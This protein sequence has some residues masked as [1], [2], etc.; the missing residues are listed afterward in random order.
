M[1]TR[2]LI[3]TTVALFS[4]SLAA[5][6]ADETMKKKSPFVVADLDANGKIS[7]SEYVAAMNGKLDETAA[8]ARFA[9]LDKD[10]DGS[11]TRQEFST[12]TGEKSS[13]RKKKD[14]K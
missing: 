14:P 6:A 10:K 11:L 5:Q 8:K 4:L 9:Q 1:K 7:E 2:T 3:A 12:A 13:G